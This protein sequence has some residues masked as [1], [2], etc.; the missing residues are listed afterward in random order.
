MQF[1]LVSWSLSVFMLSAIYRRYHNEMQYHRVYLGRQPYL[2]RIKMLIRDFNDIRRTKIVLFC[3][4]CISI[5]SPA[6]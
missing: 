2:F 6:S 3:L 4:H 1:L 5:L